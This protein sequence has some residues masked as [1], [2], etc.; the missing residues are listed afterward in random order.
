MTKTLIFTIAPKGEL[1]GI[2]LDRFLLDESGNEEE[3]RTSVAMRIECVRA[4]GDIGRLTVAKKPPSA[5]AS[6]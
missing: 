5:Q 4:R 3:A 1:W 6:R 2:W